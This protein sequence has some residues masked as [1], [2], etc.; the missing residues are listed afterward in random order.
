MKASELIAELQKKIEEIGDLP[1][2]LNSEW[3][4][5]PAVLV[6]AYDDEGR[7]L[8]HGDPGALPPTGI[9]VHCSSAA[10]TDCTPL[11]R[12]HPN[13]EPPCDVSGHCEVSEKDEQS[14]ASEAMCVHCG[15]WRYRDH[16]YPGNWGTWTPELETK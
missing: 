6:A 16:P 8:K 10:A 3:G 12:D 11:P 14:E 2:T 7:S 5:A 1:V 13:Y 9:H 4:E 15:G